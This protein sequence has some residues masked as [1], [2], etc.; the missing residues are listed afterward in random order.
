MTDIP[1]HATRMGQRFYEHTAP[2]LVRQLSRLNE[3]LERLIE[4]A[5]TKVNSDDI[6]EDSNEDRD[7]EDPEARHP[8]TDGR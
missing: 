8:R 4:A 7:S 6:D 3:N 2:E 5:E 1:F